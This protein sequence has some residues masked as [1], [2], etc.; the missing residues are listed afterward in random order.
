M[1][2][3]KSKIDRREFLAAT[4]GAAIL[5]LGNHALPQTNSASRPDDLVLFV[6]TYTS[7]ASKSKGIYSYRF[8]RVSGALTPGA[9]TN[10]VVDPSFL[11]IDKHGRYLYAVN[12]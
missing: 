11:V 12:E 9:V 1:S 10:G 2:R 7:D 4:A 5:S 8:D 3:A 6:G